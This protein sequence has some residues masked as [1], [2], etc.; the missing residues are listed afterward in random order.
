MND[1]NF[2]P[3][4]QSALTILTESNSSLPSTPTTVEE[5]KLIDETIVSIR[6]IYKDGISTTITKIGEIIFEKI[7]GNDLDCF[8]NDKILMKKHS[9]K[10]SI[11]KKLSEKS[12]ELAERGDYLPKKTFLYNAVRLV[13]DQKLLS[14]SLEYKGLSISHKIELLPIA[15]KDLKLAAIKEIQSQN[16]SVREVRKRVSSLQEKRVKKTSI[17][18]YIN[19]PE[20]IENDPNFSR[21]FF[22]FFKTK[23]NKKNILSDCE[24]KIAEITALIAKSQENVDKL[25]TLMKDLKEVNILRKNPKKKKEAKKS[26]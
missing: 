6:N 22:K 17:S 14:D 4:N 7:Y 10:W 16:L 9:N 20:K 11:F 8:S 3:D 18:Y 12:N 24:E 2:S 19:N 5:D 23:D 25:Q 15:D 13:I 26:E 21:K 1:K